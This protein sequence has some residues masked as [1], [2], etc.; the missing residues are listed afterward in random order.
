MGD[1][2]CSLADM[3][4]LRIGPISTVSVV[5]SFNLSGNVEKFSFLLML[6]GCGAGARGW[7][8][9]SSWEIAY[10]RSPVGA[11]LLAM[12]VNHNACGLSR[13]RVLECIASKPAPTG[14]ALSVCS[15][16]P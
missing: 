3:Q 4:F 15:G 9:V 6:D 1:F 7:R 10:S 2:A 5:E 14:F 16:G 11:G 8:M 12:A 13:R